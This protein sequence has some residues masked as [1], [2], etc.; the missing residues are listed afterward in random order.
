[1]CNQYHIIVGLEH[2]CSDLADGTN[3]TPKEEHIL[4]CLAAKGLLGLI[5][6]EL[7]VE[8]QSYAFLVGC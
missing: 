3:L 4:L 6:I 1:L 5:N 7:L 8:A 2:D